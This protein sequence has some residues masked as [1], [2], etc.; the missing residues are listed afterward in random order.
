MIDGGRFSPVTRV[1]VAVVLAA[2]A[3]GADGSQPAAAQD[4]NVGLAAA[5]AEA[6]L[7]HAPF[8][9]VEFRAIR[10]GGR[11]RLAALLFDAATA[12]WAKWAAAPRG[13]AADNAQPRFEV[14]A[15]RLQK[16]FLNEPEY[17]VPPTVARVVSLEDY[18]DGGRGVRATFPEAPAVLVVLQLWLQEVSSRSSWDERRFRTDSVYAR[19]VANLNVLTYL[20]RHGDSNTGNFLISRDS[21]NPRVFSVDNGIAFGALPNPDAH[22]WL[23]LRVNRLP[24][25]T[26]AR[27]RHIDTRQLEQALGVVIQ[28]ELRDGV[29]VTVEPGPNLDAGRA[30]RRQRHTV[31]LGL[32][33]REI[34]AVEQRLRLLLR[35]V[36]AGRIA[37][38]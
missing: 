25:A 26:V 24:L 16:L 27:L 2:A 12:V 9:V 35:E 8:E 36:D 38:F 1:A 13:G 7:G 34:A 15:Y 6:L 18:P 23:A 33:S 37:T 32:T 4:R 17:V 28:L 29:L 31:Q 5:E 20:I 3:S 14:G 19:H 10:P 22:E 11:S 30:V 21:A